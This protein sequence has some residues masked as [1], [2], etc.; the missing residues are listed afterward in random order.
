MAPAGGVGGPGF[1]ASS[2]AGNQSKGTLTLYTNQR[3]TRVY[4]TFVEEPGILAELAPNGSRVT[5][6]PKALE[7]WPSGVIWQATTTGQFCSVDI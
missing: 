5:R 1:M 7:W 4:L 2:Y 3:L 6:G